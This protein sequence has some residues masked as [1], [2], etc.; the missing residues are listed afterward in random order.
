MPWPLSLVLYPKP[1]YIWTQIH[2]YHETRKA[3]LVSKDPT[4]WIP[5]SRI[6]KIRLKGNV[7]EICVK[8]CI[9]G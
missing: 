3:I 1:R 5:K 2:I 7:F 4:I 6:A 9:I 8:E